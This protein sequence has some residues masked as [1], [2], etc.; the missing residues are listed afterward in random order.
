[1]FWHSCWYSINFFVMLAH[2]KYPLVGQYFYNFRWLHAWWFIF[3]Q[4]KTPALY[5]FSTGI[6]QAA[7]NFRRAGDKSYRL[8]ELARRL[9]RV[10]SVH[11]VR[12]NFYS[13]GENLNIKRPDRQRDNLLWRS[14]HQCRDKNNITLMYSRKGDLPA[15]EV[16]KFRNY[17]ITFTGLK[18]KTGCNARS[19]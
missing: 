8:S 6:L 14:I 12:K 1:M 9:D 3:S 19:V 5:T 13:L 10:M 18:I 16:G 2:V 17:S 11:F 15:Q 7:H 4:S